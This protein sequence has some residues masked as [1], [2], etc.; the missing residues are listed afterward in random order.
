MLAVVVRQALDVTGVPGSSAKNWQTNTVKSSSSV[1]RTKEVLGGLLDDEPTHTEVFDFCG[2]GDG[3]L[4]TDV[5]SR[6]MGP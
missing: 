5:G 1:V 6:P 2:C 4:F 3:S